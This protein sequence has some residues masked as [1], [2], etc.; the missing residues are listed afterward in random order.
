M[1]SP[2]KQAAVKAAKAYKKKLQR[3]TKQA[4]GDLHLAKRLL[5]CKAE[6]QRRTEQKL[7]E[8]GRFKGPFTKTNKRSRGFV[9][10]QEA[11]SELLAERAWN[12]CHPWIRQ[13]A[14]FVEMNDNHN[15]PGGGDDPGGEQPQQQQ[16]DV[17]FADPLPPVDQPRVEQP[18]AYT[19]DGKCQLC[20]VPE[21]VE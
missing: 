7:Q 12:D 1:V 10:R 18:G 11:Y 5:A 8:P 2:S 17:F 6:I 19:H 4:N 21:F 16:P 3:W 20:L 15:P 13:Q 14:K 9:T